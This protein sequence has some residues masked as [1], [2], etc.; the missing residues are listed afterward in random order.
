[1]P[2][3]TEE[4]RLAYASKHNTKR[5][6]QVI[7]L[8]ITDDEKW[9]YL[10]VKKLST[11]P[12]GI[13]SKHVA[14]FYCLNFLHSYSTKNKLEKHYNVCKSDDYCYIE[15]TNEDNKILKYIHGEKSMQKRIQY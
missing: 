14:E 2:H 15:M 7:L 6:N 4:I 8:I 13:T 10:S 11:L 9:H 12:R 5:K 3:N 1:M